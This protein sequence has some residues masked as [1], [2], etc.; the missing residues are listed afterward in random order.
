MVGD[1][2][3]YYVNPDGTFV[4]KTFKSDKDIVEAVNNTITDKMFVEWAHGKE[5]V[6]DEGKI[7][8]I[9]GIYSG[10]EFDWTCLPAWANYI[11]LDKDGIWS[12]YESEPTPSEDFWMPASGGSGIIRQ[13]FYPHNTFGT[14]KDNCHKKPSK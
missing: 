6:T 11:A 1:G 2:L 12:W 14:W 10:L 13:D 7:V 4:D 5:F 9:L 8:R 3:T